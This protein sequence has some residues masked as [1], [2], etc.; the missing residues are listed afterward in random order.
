MK[1]PKPA[2]RDCLR[3]LLA[4]RSSKRV[5]NITGARN[6]QMKMGGINIPTNTPM[7]APKPPF[8]VA[9]NFFTPQ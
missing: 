4:K 1:A 6:I 8:Q 9:P 2:L 7:V 5:A 3:L